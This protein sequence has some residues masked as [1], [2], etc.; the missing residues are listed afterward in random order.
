MN[1]V[2]TIILASAAIILTLWWVLM[3]AGIIAIAVWV[4]KAIGVA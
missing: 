4:L 2:L 3:L 1:Q